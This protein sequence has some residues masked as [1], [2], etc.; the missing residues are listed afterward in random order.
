MA[1]AMGIEAISDLADSYGSGRYIRLENHGDSIQGCFVGQPLAYEIVWVGNG[2]EEYDPTNPLHKADEVR[3]VVAWN[4]FDREKKEM[5]VW[6][7]GI[8]FFRQWKRQHDKHGANQWFTIERDGKAGSKKTTY[9]LE[10]DGE[11]DPEE[12]ASIQGVALHSLEKSPRESDDTDH[13][14]AAELLDAKSPRESD[15]IPFGG[16]PA[17]T[18]AVANDLKQRLK[19]M[20]EEAIDKFLTQFEVSRIRDVPLSK[21][22]S[23]I[24]FVDTLESSNSPAQNRREVDPFA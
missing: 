12:W 1:K 11:V 10:R 3:M 16:E 4:F 19:E 14:M 21:E 17:M 7:R 22:A 18:S 9:L 5:R 20:P 6:E 15:D 13:R 2:S 8:T 24:R 23:A